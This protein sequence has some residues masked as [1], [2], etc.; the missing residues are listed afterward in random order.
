MISDPEAAIL[1][2][3]IGSVS[4]LMGVWLGFYLSRRASEKDRRSE[5]LFSVY[6]EV[7]SLGNLL[8][9]VQ[10]QMIDKSVFYRKWAATTENI[11]RALI[12]SDIDRKRILNAINVKW[13]DPASVVEV[14]ALA[15]DL[16]K[17]LDPEYY[18]AGKELCKELGVKPEDI[19]PIVLS[20]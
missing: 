20:K 11:M 1:A 9:A 18:R 16:L 14:Q 15:D 3:L 7:E 10:K 17:R 6:I 5:K 8:K 12:G 19:D 4:G 2:G 13:D